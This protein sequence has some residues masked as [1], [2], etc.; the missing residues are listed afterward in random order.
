MTGTLTFVVQASSPA[1]AM[2][3]GNQRNNFSQWVPN[4]AQPGT[5]ISRLVMAYLLDNPIRQLAA[6]RTGPFIAAGEFEET[7]HIWDVCNRCFIRT[8]STP[9]DFGGSRMAI[10]TDGRACVTGSYADGAVVCYCVASG[11][12]LWRRNEVEHPE[13]IS[14]TPDDRR[15]NLGSGQR[16]LSFDRMD[17]KTLSAERGVHRI[18]ESPWDNAVFL[19]GS[20]MKL[21]GTN[22]NAWL[23]SRIT[24][25][26]LAVAFGQNT[27]CVSESGGPAR[28]WDVGNGAEMWH[29]HEEGRHI[30]SLAY[31]AMEDIFFAIDLEYEKTGMSRLLR[32]ACRSGRTDVVAVI[33]GGRDAAFC[34]G[35]SRLVTPDGS[36]FDTSTGALVGRLWASPQARGF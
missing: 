11:D 30:V 8:L 6:S 7:V 16:V 34:L 4:N 13:N 10:S 32:I 22:G 25:A 5:I 31:N 14:F 36:V 23:L 1:V 20:K 9:L 35:G 15:I 24:F 18:V 28:C 17:G 33:N 2:D 29:R 26:E 12:E 21:V 19:G 3:L 27:L